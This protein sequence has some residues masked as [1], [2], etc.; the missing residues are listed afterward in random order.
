MNIYGVEHDVIYNPGGGGT[1]DRNG[2]GEEYTV[3]N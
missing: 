1:K 2:W 3:Y